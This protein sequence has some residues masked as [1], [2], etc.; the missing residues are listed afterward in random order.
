MTSS[1]T[2]VYDHVLRVHV[3]V[4]SYFY[5]S[6]S[7]YILKPNFR[8]PTP[9]KWMKRASPCSSMACLATAG[10]SVSVDMLHWSFDASLA[11]TK[12]DGHNR[13]YKIH[14]AR[15]YIMS[16]N[17]CTDPHWKS[18]GYRPPK[19]DSSDRFPT[20]VICFMNSSNIPRNAKH[21]PW[22]CLRIV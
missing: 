15:L 16:I 1:E 13:N 4:S 3:Y 17:P 9:K 11:Q 21:E 5:E 7:W 12:N 19:L 2:Q 18:Q 8:H 20:P 14:I 22:Q 6:L 10:S